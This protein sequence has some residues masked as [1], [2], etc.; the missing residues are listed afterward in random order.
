VLNQPWR[1]RQMSNK[2]DIIA[3]MIPWG[4]TH[5]LT[6]DYNGLIAPIGAYNFKAAVW[7]QGE[8]DLY[9]ASRYRSNMAA[10]MG[11][12]RAQFRNPAMPFLIVQIPNYGDIPTKPTANYWS[13]VREGQRLGVK[14]DKYAALTVNID[15]GDPASLHPTNKQEVGRRLAIA[16]RHIAYGEA[17]APSGP[18]VAGAARSGENVTVRFTGITGKLV[19]RSGV[20]GFELCGATQGSCRWAA[21]GISGN[22]V[23]LAN[24]GNATRVRYCWGE[25]PVCTLYDT[26]GLPAGPF[27]QKIAAK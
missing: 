18:E 24:A 13:D 14:D 25:A 4:P 3:P 21:A 20:N 9:F 8:S 10:M 1:Y 27:E 26:S 6:M 19:G 16:A 23:T 17:I 11:D 2:D 22:S 15:I 12:W 7:Y 5:G